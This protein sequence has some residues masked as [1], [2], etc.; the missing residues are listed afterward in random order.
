M[1]N[2]EIVAVP[3]NDVAGKLKTVPEDNQMI[4]AARKVG[5]SFGD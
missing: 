4:A 2:G 3:L 5:I 1:K